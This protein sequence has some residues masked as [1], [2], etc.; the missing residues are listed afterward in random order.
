METKYLIYRETSANKHS[1]FLKYVAQYE[2]LQEAIDALYRGAKRWNL[3]VNI[4]NSVDPRCGFCLWQIYIQVGDWRYSITQTEEDN[5]CD[6][7]GMFI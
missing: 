4:D 5:E 2:N 7:F 3:N 1:A 6:L